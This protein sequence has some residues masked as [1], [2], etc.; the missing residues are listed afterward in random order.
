MPVCWP[1][2][3]SFKESPMGTVTMTSTGSGR[4]GPR[5]T[6]LGGIAGRVMVLLPQRLGQVPHQVL[7]LCHGITLDV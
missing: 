4:K 5:T 2:P 7:K 3:M 1:L 6:A